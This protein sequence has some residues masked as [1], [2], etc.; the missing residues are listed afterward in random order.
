M[1][2]A[3]IS[4]DAKTAYPE[5]RPK[6][7]EGDAEAPANPAEE[8]LKESKGP[9]QVIVVADVDMLAD[10]MWVNEQ[11]FFGQKI[12]RPTADNGDFLVNAVDNLSGSTDLI[13]LRSRGRSIRP[14]DKVDELRRDAE[15]RFRTREKELEA[16]LQDATQKINELQGSKDQ[17]AAMILS[18]EQEAEIERFKEERNKTRKELRG[19]KADLQKDIE[20]L[21]TELVLLNGLAVPLLVAFAGIGVWSV[22]RKK[23]VDARKSPARE[24][25]R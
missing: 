10:R 20:A 21:K 22:R 17:A 14:F 7:Q 11:N 6:K 9:I 8:A 1:L 2:A 24:L 16:K 5:G 19:V 15:T 25:T 3:R 23:M 13:S 4:G 18:P 12:A